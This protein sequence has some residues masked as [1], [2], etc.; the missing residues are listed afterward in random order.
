MTDNDITSDSLSKTN[1]PDLQYKKNK[2]FVTIVTIIA[3]LLFGIFF[4]VTMKPVYGSC[5]YIGGLCYAQRHYTV[6]NLIRDV[7]LIIFIVSGLIYLTK[8][9]HH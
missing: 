7:S 2:K 6:G 1:D 9:R 4:L 5:I 8:F 3:F